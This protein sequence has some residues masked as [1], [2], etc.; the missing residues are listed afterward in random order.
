MVY[1]DFSKNIKCLLRPCRVN[2][3]NEGGDLYEIN[4]PG[5]IFVNLQQEWFLREAEEAVSGKSHRPMSEENAFWHAVCT[6]D[7]EFVRQ[8][9]KQ[10]K[11]TESEG[12]G[13]LSRDPVTN[14]KYHLVVTTA[15]ITRLCV[16]FGMEM[17]QAFRLSDFYILKLDNIHTVQGV[18][19]LHDQMV[20]D[21]TGK[22][23]LL[24]KTERTSKSVADCIEY[25]YVHIQDRITLDDLASHTG[26]SPSHLSRLFKKETGVS[27]SDYIR[28]KKVEK[29]QELLQFC[30]FSLIEIS[31]YLSFSSQSHFTQLFRAFTGM[32]PKK[33]RD[34]R[35]NKNLIGRNQEVLPENAP[36]AGQD[37]S[38]SIS[39]HS[40]SS[41]SGM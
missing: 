9:C 10:K 29:A 34:L 35:Q 13:V 41:V 39:D 33:Y 32:T 22:M 24:A 18:E 36:Q 4:K 14:L 3:E 19:N 37:I 12:V 21:F 38:S 1:N 20:L 15:M 8:N 2:V 28:E 5:G 6:G 25:I 7:L 23:R 31:S 26:L 17:E 16:E 30:D 40:F 27:V 11:F